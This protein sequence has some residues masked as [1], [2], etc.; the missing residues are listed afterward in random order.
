MMKATKQ[1][2]AQEGR[3][4]D[5]RLF[6]VDKT[7]RTG[8]SLPRCTRLEKHL[9]IIDSRLPKLEIGNMLGGTGVCRDN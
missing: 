6:G 8:S 4:E 2:Q 1:C 3:E 9:I 5:R 7:R